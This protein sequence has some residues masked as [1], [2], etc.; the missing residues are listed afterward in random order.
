ECRAKGPTR[1]GTPP[2]PT[3]PLSEA[4][5]AAGALERRRS[6][7]VKL[8]RPLE[9]R[10]ELVVPGEQS[11]AARDCRKRPGA[12][13]LA[14]RTLEVGQRPFRVLPAAEAKVRLDQVGLPL[15]HAGLPQTVLGRP[16]GKRFQL[17]ERFVEAAEPELE[18]AEA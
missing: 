16:A 14:R 4:E 8:E 13:G 7:A 11:T 12:P 1:V 18:Q 2:C 9:L 5:L 15:D 6:A 10:F 17:I 3:E